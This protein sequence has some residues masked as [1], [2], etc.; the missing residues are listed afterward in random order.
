[1]LTSDKKC[2]GKYN[3]DNEISQENEINRLKM[4]SLYGEILN[5]Q[6]NSVATSTKITNE[7]INTLTTPIYSFDPT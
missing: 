2:C 4:S 3:K 7:Y 1:M 6:S 5:N